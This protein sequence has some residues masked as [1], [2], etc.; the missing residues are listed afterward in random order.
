MHMEKRLL[1]TLASRI[2]K[3]ALKITYWDGTTK[4]YGSGPAYLTLTLNSPRAVR[5]ILRNMTVGFGESY[6]EGLIDIDGPLENIGRLVSENA[7]AFNT[8]GLTR[9]TR[10]TNS[11]R[12]SK[13]KQQI[14]HHYDLGN[15]FYK[16]WLDASMT[17][18]CAYFRKKSI[19]FYVNYSSVPATG[20]STSDRG[21]APCS[22]PLLRNMG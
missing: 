1:H 10:L 19:I 12:A 11:N 4:T 9:L 16:L 13:Q 7:A 21:G 5:A 20:C 14:Q 22:L 17:Y 18:S 8:L 3:G 6:M 2:R 15:D